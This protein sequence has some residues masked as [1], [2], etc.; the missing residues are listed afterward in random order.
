[1]MAAQAGKQINVGH[2]ERWISAGVGALLAMYG[3]KRMRLGSI[4]L[5]AGGV[6]LLQRAITGH[7]DLYQM[8][9]MNTADGAHGEGAGARPE[10]YFD[11]GI[12]VKES[13]V[14][15]RPAEELYNFWH[16]FENLPRFMKHLKSVK[17][18]DDK[19][20]HWVVEG[21][22]GMNVE[23]YAE[24]INDEPNRVIAWRSLGGADVDN[25]GSVRFIPAQ[26][27]NGTEVSVTLDYIPPAGRAG[28][29]MAKIFGHDADQMVRE[30]LRGFKVLMKSGEVA[31][32]G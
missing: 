20:S 13:F 3:L 9:G 29:W 31:K 24:I 26:S 17:T 11:R 6:M 22:A 12:H 14:I 32:A 1:M 15:D 28:A 18:L 21:P 27:G 10:E 16:N 25:A 4:L 23:W 30:D 7:C 5:G 2:E 19:R 8:F